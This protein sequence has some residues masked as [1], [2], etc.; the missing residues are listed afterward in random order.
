MILGRH[1]LLYRATAF[2][3]PCMQV[4]IIIIIIIISVSLQ[5]TRRRQQAEAAL[6]RQKATE[7]R[8][9][10]DPEAL[11]RK[12][13][14]KEEMERRA[15]SQPIANA[16]AGLRVSALLKKLNVKYMNFQFQLFE[17]LK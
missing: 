11:K 16:G 4:Y 7:G 5:E 3:H 10:K 13:Q 2:R 14:R 15:E 8:G 9:V 17:L 1:G 6:Q 12:Q